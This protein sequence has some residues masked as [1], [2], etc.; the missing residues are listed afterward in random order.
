MRELRIGSQAQGEHT[1]AA[2]SDRL[3]HSSSN[4]RGSSRAGNGAGLS[5]HAAVTSSSAS[6]ARVLAA[7]LLHAS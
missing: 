3:R 2:R 7:M 6:S 4:A 5:A 1:S